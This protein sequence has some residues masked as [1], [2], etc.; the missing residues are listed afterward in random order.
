M[1]DLDQWA[2]FK[3]FYLDCGSVGVALDISRMDFAGGFLEEMEPRIQKAFEFMKALEGGAIANPDENRMVGHYWLRDSSKAP[4][5]EI[6]KEIDT[7]LAKIKKFARDVHAGK[8]RPQKARQF[9]NVLVI[10][11]GGSALGPQFVALALGSAAD[12]L[13]PYF[14][15][16]TDP[17]GIDSVLARIGA[18]LKE[19]IAVVISKSGGTPETRNGMLEASAAYEKMGLNFGKH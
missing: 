3:N 7:C 2:R 1:S 9:K 16:N 15:D 19:T 8:I 10:G 6:K 12:K 17:E 5:V 4:N 13:K 11:I 18:G 14:F